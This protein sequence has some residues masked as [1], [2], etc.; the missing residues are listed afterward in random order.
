MNRENLETKKKNHLSISMM[1]NSKETTKLFSEKNILNS[2]CQHQYQEIMC[3]VILYCL[4]V[5][6][7]NLHSNTNML[8]VNRH[9]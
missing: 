9:W 5:L 8:Y 4:F 2:F 1:K 6:S 3:Y 7:H